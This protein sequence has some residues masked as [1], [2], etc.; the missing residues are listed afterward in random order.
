MTYSSIPETQAH[1]LRVAELIDPLAADLDNRAES[2]DA[3]KTETP[4]VETFDEFTP[5]LKDSTYGSDEYKGFLEAM[6]EGLQHHYANNRHHPEHFDDGIK[7]MTLVD[8]IEML[9]DWKA[10]GERH[11]NGSMERSLVVQQKRF[12]IDPQLNRILWN[13]AEH[14]GWLS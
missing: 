12:S 4:E 2:H 6:G 5:K 13:T 8:L 3:S 1:A 9:A 11:A 14:Y 7:G 10:A